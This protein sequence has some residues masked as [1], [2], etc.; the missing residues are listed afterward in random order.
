MNAKNP[1]K[2]VNNSTFLKI[3]FRSL[4]F[5]RLKTGK[6]PPAKNPT[7]VTDAPISPNAAL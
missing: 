5:S 2:K 4:L 7:I 6:A 1:A 3:L